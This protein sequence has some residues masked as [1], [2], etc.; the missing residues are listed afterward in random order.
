MGGVG[1]NATASVMRTRKTKNPKGSATPNAPEKVME[2]FGWLDY[3]VGQ[4]SHLAYQAKLQ[5]TTHL[6]VCDF[7]AGFADQKVQGLSLT[8]AG[9]SYEVLLID[10]PM[11]MHDHLEA[12]LRYVGVG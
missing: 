1:G 8:I 4:P 3:Q 2:V 9:E 10:D 7:D 6:W 12:Y 5:D 11:G